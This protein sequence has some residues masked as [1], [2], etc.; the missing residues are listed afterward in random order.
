MS[1][2]KEE[3]KEMKYLITAAILVAVS[4][5]SSPPAKAQAACAQTLV[6]T[7]TRAYLERNFPGWRMVNVDDLSA[8]HKQLWLKDHRK[9][10]PGITT[11]RFEPSGNWSTAVL[12]ISKTPSDSRA[13]V[14]LIN[15]TRWTHRTLANFK[16]ARPIPV[17]FKAPRGSYQSWD[18]SQKVRSKYSVIALVT[19][20]ASATAFYWSK[21]KFCE[22]AISD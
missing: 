14:I 18:D 1:H 20:E 5:L 3:N 13:K 10:C 22:I 6:S 2:P 12:L 16:D 19:Y 9:E 7:A 11:G 21:G 8:D 4:L 17:L 15:T